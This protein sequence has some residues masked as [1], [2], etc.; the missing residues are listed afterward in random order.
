M[1]G[2]V[3]SLVRSN[4]K[5]PP[6]VIVPASVTCGVPLCAVSVHPSS[7]TSVAPELNSSIHSA[8]AFSAVPIQSISFIRTVAWAG[9]ATLRKSTAKNP[10]ASV[11]AAE[12]PIRALLFPPAARVLSITKVPPLSA[13]VLL[14]AI[15][16]V[17]PL[18]CSVP[19]L[20]V[21][22]PV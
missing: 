19:A 8:F 9:D 14:P 11:N 2:T 6:A 12:S 21:V 18:S 17:A 1:P 10:T 16:P 22:V 20:M 3:A 15:V 5:K 4:K 7:D 13:T